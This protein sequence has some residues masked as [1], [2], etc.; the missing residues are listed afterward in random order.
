MS[1]VFSDI[2]E[3]SNSLREALDNTLADFAQEKY[4][5]LTMALRDLL[6]QGQSPERLDWILRNVLHNYRQVPAQRRGQMLAALGCYARRE[7]K[8]LQAQLTLI[9]WE[10]QQGAAR[11]AE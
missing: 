9:E 5:R 10:R 4:P 11:A 8:R 3:L 2:P 1:E 7:H 6:Q